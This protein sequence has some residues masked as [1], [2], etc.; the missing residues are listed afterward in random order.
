V[1]R[2]SAGLLAYR[3]QHDG[4]LELLLVHP[5][6]PFWRNKDAHAWSVPKG[7]YEEGA[8]PSREAA[9]EF[10]EELGVDA[11]RGPLLDLGTVRQSNGKQVH[12][13]A[14]EARTLVV[15]EVVSNQF[16]LE[17]PPKSGRV[18]T[19]PEVDRAEWMTI[20]EA[21]PRIVK[22]QAEFLGR[23]ADALSGTRGVS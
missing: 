4:T 14:V 16:E 15:D 6:G 17:W 1:P 12:V 11:P 5:G 21:R 10:T 8:D 7:E 20:P 18:Q 2:L 23:L 13:W 3:H 19:F 9:R 22:A